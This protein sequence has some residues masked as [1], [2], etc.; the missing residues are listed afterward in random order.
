MRV[1]LRDNRER[2]P[3]A[4]ISLS[5]VLVLFGLFWLW[6]RNNIGHYT[7][8]APSQELTTSPHVAPD[9]SSLEASVVNTPIPDFENAL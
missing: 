5:I 9:F 1:T 8:P 2:S 4:L 7:E 3:W 6:Q